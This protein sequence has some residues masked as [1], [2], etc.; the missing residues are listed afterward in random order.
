MRKDKR[1][2]RNF[3]KAY[4]AVSRMLSAVALCVMAITGAL[5]YYGVLAGPV[6]QTTEF[7]IFLICWTFLMFSL[8][9][10]Q[11]TDTATK[12]EKR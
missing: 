10:L 5:T 8:D 7:I 4:P 1:H 6:W 12:G 2:F 11:E 3:L 9:V